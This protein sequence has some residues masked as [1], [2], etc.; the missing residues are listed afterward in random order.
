MLTIIAIEAAMMPIQRPNCDRPNTRNPE[1]NTR[2]PQ[3]SMIQ[4]QVSTSPYIS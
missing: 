3:I 2:I 4:P 1:I